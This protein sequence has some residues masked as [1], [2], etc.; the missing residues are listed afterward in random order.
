M[1]NY[2][3]SVSGQYLD[4]LPSVIENLQ[5]Q[6][7]EQSGSEIPESTIATAIANYLAQH[8]IT[9][10]NTT[11]TVSVSGSVLTLTPSTG[12]AQTVNLPSVTDSHINDLIDA[13][14]N[15]LGTAEGGSY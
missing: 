13:K 7:D 14:I 5:A 1:S 8:P 12:Q 10:T 4:S 2:K 6:I 9:D 3:L 11:Y 15:A